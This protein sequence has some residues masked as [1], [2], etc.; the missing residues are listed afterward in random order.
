MVR[1][2]ILLSLFT[3]FSLTTVLK[4]K[5]T[6]FN[7]IFMYQ[8]WYK[9]FKLI[10]SSPQLNLVYSYRTLVPTDYPISCHSYWTS[11]I[12]Q[13]SSL[14]VIYFILVFKSFSPK[15]LVEMSANCRPL[16]YQP[17]LCIFQ[18]SPFLKTFTLLAIC[19]VCLVSILLLAIQKADLLPNTIKWSSSG[20]ISGSLFKNSLINTLKC[21]KVITAVNAALYSLYELDW[22]TG[23]GTCVP[24]SDIPPWLN[25]LYA[26]LL[27]PVYGQ[28]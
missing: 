7:G 27:L 16:S 6:V 14:T 9:Y 26:P 8:T 20:D 13:L 25:I 18:F 17:I 24:W 23:P 11:V 22:S 3:R 19:L 5:S 28:S 21:A 1:S 2:K 15:F 10:G 12:Y 4:Q